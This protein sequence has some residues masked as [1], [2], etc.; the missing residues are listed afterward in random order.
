MYRI[1]YDAQTSCA[2]IKDHACIPM[3]PPR[4]RRE[5]LGALRLSLMSE[6][7]MKF[8]SD[9]KPAFVADPGLIAPY[10][11]SFVADGEKSCHAH[12]PHITLTRR[13][14]PANEWIRLWKEDPEGVACLLKDAN[15]RRY[16]TMAWN[17]VAQKVTRCDAT[18]SLL[19]AALAGFVHTFE[20][21]LHMALAN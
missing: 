5:E 7:A 3:A 12:F 4:R 1:L 15:V 13:P 21:T 11:F 9:A 2:Y 17:G 6:Q 20:N 14:R 10:L 8:L 18:N 16:L 19:A